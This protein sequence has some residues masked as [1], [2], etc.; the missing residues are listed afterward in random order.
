MYLKSG[1]SGHTNLCRNKCKMKE[2][3]MLNSAINSH[4]AA[5][6]DIDRNAYNAAFYELGLRWHWDADTYQ[7][8]LSNAEEKDRIRVYLETQQPHLL[9]AYDADFLIQAIQTTK[10][11]CYD[12]MAACGA[13]NAGSINWA[14]IQS[15][16]VGA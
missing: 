13:K 1:V 5:S 14:E 9:R 16:E 4:P 12:N 15:V 3:A 2:S 7:S 11:R 8:L 6:V 10:A